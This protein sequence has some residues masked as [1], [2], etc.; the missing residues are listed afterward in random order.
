LQELT[1]E[2][3]PLKVTQPEIQP[4]VYQPQVLA[5]QSSPPLDA[6]TAVTQ[7]INCPKGSILTIVPHEDDDI[8]FTSPDLPDEIRS[9]RCAITIYL[10]A[11]DAGGAARY[12]ENREL[13]AETAYSTM[14][15]QD[16]AVWHHSTVQ[17]NGHENLDGQGFPSTGYASLKKLYDNSIDTIQSIDGSASYSSQDLI[18]TLRASM[19]M[20][21]P[22]QIRTLGYDDDFSAGDH[23]DHNVASY[24]TK[25]AFLGYTGTGSLRTYM[26]YPGGSMPENIP[27]DM[28]ATKESVFYAYGAHDPWV[29]KSNVTCANSPYDSYLKHQYSKLYAR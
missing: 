10:T 6:M 24:F 16:G 23:S 14:L 11:G 13:G 17:V 29:C 27:E 25:Q 26:G 15:G 7:A 20:Y 12:W 21:Q 4:Q 8:L 9:G 5:P 2:N 19:D 1:V 28:L 18:A 22:S 3:E